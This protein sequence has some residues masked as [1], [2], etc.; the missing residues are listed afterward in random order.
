[1]PDDTG[2]DLV[3]GAFSYTGRAVARRLLAFGRRVK[4]LTAH[5]DRPPRHSGSI[6]AVPYTF[7]DPDRLARQERH[8]SMFGGRAHAA[9]RPVRLRNYEPW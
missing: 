3:T 1:M 7:D 4:T 8:D 2:L 6:E 5:P 9:F